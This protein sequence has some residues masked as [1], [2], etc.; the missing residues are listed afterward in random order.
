TAKASN[1]RPRPSS[2][3]PRQKRRHR[4]HPPMVFAIKLTEEG[5]KSFDEEH[6]G[7]APP[8]LNGKDYEEWWLS[9]EAALA[10]II[11]SHCMAFFGLPEVNS[12]SGL[13]FV[14]DGDDM[15][16]SVAFVDSTSRT[17]V[18]PTPELVAKVGKYIHQEGDQPQW[19]KLAILGD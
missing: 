13:A 11:P 4:R 8:G 12:D 15:A 17:R 3:T 18:I 19:Y 7:P 14:H 2:S 16:P 9:R 1:R 10:A 6:F 5:M